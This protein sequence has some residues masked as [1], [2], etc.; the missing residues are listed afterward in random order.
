MLKILA[1]AVGAGFGAVG[2]FEILNRYTKHRS[3]P[4]GH[5]D[6]GLARAKGTAVP[7]VPVA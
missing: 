1:A 5:S 3:A 2:I 6:A 4:K 7:T